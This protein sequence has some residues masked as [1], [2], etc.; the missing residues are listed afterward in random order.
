M[1]R[2]HLSGAIGVLCMMA[3][4]AAADTFTKHPARFQVGPNP[5][6][7]VVEDLNADGTPDIVT[8]D[9]GELTGLREERPANDELSLLVSQGPL[10]YV[11]RPP[12]RAGF[13]PYC[14]V[15]ANIDALKAPDLIV[16]SFHDP[17]RRHLTLFR[18]LGESGFEPLTFSVPDTGLRY[19][20]M[21]D[22][23]RLPLYTVPGLTSLVVRE[24]NHDEFR[25]VAATGWSADTI[26][27]FPG[28]GEKYFGDPIL[29][30]AP[31]GP[32]SV[33]AADLNGDGEVDLVTAMYN[34]GEVAVWKGAGNGTFAE[35]NR[36]SSGGPLPHSVRLADFNGDGRTDIAVAH[37]FTTDSVDLFFGDADRP[38]QFDVHQRMTMAPDDNFQR[39]DDEIR[40]L[41]A[42]DLNLDGKPDLAAAC[43]ASGKVRVFI[44][45][46]QGTG[47][48]APF[49][50]ETYAFK[51]G[52][53]RALAAADLNA[54]GKP[55][56]AVA[57]W[58]SNTVALLLGQ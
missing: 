42:Q 55:D 41:V 19:A 38:F 29:T 39:V 2:R 34:T 49:R 35:T 57:L 5:C 1:T 14:V 4:A 23:D 21:L 43:Y 16:A 56:L 31:G 51:D 13:A 50:R 20:R 46:S 18:N 3:A 32:R 10:D 33:Q 12:L 48:P 17:R 54:D 30:P 8:A 25:D 11:A 45:E 22:N 36:F 27:F 40:D 9:R 58:Q 26:V 37:C 44:N 6:S 47:A 7:I 28:D 53:P 15:A 52:R 24:M